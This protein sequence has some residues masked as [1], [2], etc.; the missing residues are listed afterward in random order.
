MGC[1]LN[2][3]CWGGVC[4]GL[5]WAVTF[6]YGSPAFTQQVEQARVTIP[7]ELQTVGA[8]G[9]IVPV[10]YSQLDI[11]NERLQELQREYVDAGK[12]SGKD[13]LRFRKAQ[14]RWARHAEAE[15]LAKRFGTTVEQM[16]GTARKLR[17]LPVH[18]AQL[19]GLINA[20]LISVLLSRIFYR[21]RRQGVVF[22]WMLVL[23]G[24][25]RIILEVIRTDNPQDTL[26]LTISQAVSVGML[27]AAVLWFLAIYRLPAQSPRAVPLEAD[28][29][30]AAK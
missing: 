20:L 6:P 28:R 18:P 2:G 19:Y 27:I 25:S 29:Q 7:A 14:M 26:G 4:A 16:A 13:S 9:Q 11:S 21:R 10:P 24:L 5:P 30:P 15:Q 23:Y 22:G 17:S 3:C 8:H 1:F 12:E